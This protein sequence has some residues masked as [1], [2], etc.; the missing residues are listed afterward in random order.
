MVQIPP[1]ADTNFDFPMEGQPD[2]FEWIIN[3]PPD[4]TI[5]AEYGPNA[6]FWRTS[7]GQT[8]AKYE[9]TTTKLEPPTLSPL[10]RGLENASSNEDFFQESIEHLRK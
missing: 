9:T 7:L 4:K 8:M 1:A 2:T 10:R 3:H 6:P 5:E